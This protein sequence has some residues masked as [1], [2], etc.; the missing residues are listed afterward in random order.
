LVHAPCSYL[1]FHTVLDTIAAIGPTCLLA[2]VDVKDA[3]CLLRV[4]VDDHY[5]LGIK[6]A[7]FYMYERCISFGVHPGPSLFE[8]FA[9]AVEA[10]IRSRGVAHC[11]HYLDDSLLISKP[12]DA[13]REYKTTLGVF[14]DLKIPLSE[15]KLSPPSPP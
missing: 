14:S 13:E 7:G 10:I 1:R 6:F 15:D 2:K 11:P 4:H 8:H 5:N 9:T 3:F 12:E